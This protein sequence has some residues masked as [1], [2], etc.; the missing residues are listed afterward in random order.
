LLTKA[1]ATEILPLQIDSHFRPW[2]TTDDVRLKCAEDMVR[3]TD[4]HK[5]QRILTVEA[6]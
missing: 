6:V 4:F 5:N 3:R 2:L 1:Q